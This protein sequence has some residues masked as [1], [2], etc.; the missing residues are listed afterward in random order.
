M[1]DHA[2][3]GLDFFVAATLLNLAINGTWTA[4]AATAVAESSLHQ[5]ACVLP[6]PRGARRAL[7]AS[8]GSRTAARRPGYVS[9]DRHHHR[10]PDGPFQTS[11][12]RVTLPP[13]AGPVALVPTARFCGLIILPRT[14][15]EE[16]TPTV[17]FGLTPICWAVTFCRLAKSTFEEVSDPS[18][19]HPEPPD[20]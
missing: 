9:P 5:A 16:F 8:T 2:S 1:L 12:Q 14:P 11:A 3:L 7:R 13:P 6:W 17:R 10:Q 4:V 18:E 20:K 19:S 15:P